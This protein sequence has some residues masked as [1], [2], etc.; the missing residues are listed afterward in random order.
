MSTLDATNAARADAEPTRYPV[1]LRI[2]VPFVPKPFFI[3]LII[4]P[5]RRGIERRRL[6]RERHPINTW[7]NLAVAVTAWTVL[8]VA[9]LFVGFVAAGL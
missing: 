7:G 8:S 6:E 5:E 4:G 9:T 2:T 1:N 3:T